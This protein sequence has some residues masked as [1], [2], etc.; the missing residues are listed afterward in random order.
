M[1]GFPEYNFPLFNRVEHLLKEEGFKNIENPASNGIPDYTDEEDLWQKCM[2][3]SLAQLKKCDSIVMLP[4]WQDSRGAK[5]EYM[6][7]FKAQKHIMFVCPHALKDGEL[8]FI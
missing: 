8:E 3:L 5:K 1:T 2:K 7:A 4:G 6:T